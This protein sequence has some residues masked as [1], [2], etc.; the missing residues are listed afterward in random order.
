MTDQMKES[1]LSKIKKLQALTTERGATPE[2]AAS[3]A[4][5]AQALLFE[6]NLAQADIDTQE[7]APDPYGKVETVLEG[8]NRTTVQW[9][10]SLLYIVAKY[11]FCSAVT[12]SGTTKMS[13][14]GKRSNVETVLY[15]NAVLVREIERLAL[16]AGR[17]V[18][19]QRSA[20]MV[21]FCRGAVHTIKHRLA[22]QQ[23]QS[24]HRATQSGTTQADADRG[25]HN[26]IA[27]RTMAQELAKAEKHFYPNLVTRRTR[28]RIGSMDGYANG[29]QAGHGI[30]MH[31]GISAGRPAGYLS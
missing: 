26:A 19:S 27:I 6:H 20:Y 28:S 16:E 18:L 3:A 30:G 4:A 11:N 9:R 17:T 8:A 21:S 2:E 22:E 10:R 13:V 25:N 7:A 29:Q 14:I 1:I 23:R 5:K 12:L 15:L 24:E 31:R